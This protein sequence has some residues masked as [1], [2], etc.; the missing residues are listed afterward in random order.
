MLSKEKLI[1]NVEE[2]YIPMLKAVNIP[3]F[4]K[5]IA[6]FSGLHIK[7]VDDAVMKDYLLTWAKN[8]YRFYLKLGKKLKM[9]TQITYKDENIDTCTKMRGLQKEYF[10]F[11]LWLEEFRH[12]ENNKIHE[13]EVTWNIREIVN[14]LFPECRLEGCSLTHFFKSFL[15]APD[16][17]VNKIGRIWENQT[18]EGN[19][20]ISIDPIDM[21]L[22][23]ENP[24]EWVSCY[25]LALDN[26]GSHADGC[27]AAILDDSS[28]ITY[29]WSSEGKF[30]L[31][32]NYNFKN[33]RY[34]KMRKWI[35]VS[36]S[37]NAIHFNI[38]YP[39][40][41]SYSKEFEQTLRKVVEDVFNKDAIWKRNEDSG[42]N[43][44]RL[45]PYG[46]SE[47]FYDDIYITK[48]SEEEDWF[49]YNERIMCPCGCGDFLV[50][51]HDAE[52]DMGNCYNYNGEG[53]IAENFYVE[54]AEDEWCDYADD[55]CSAQDC[56]NCAI[57]NRYHPVC[58]LDHE[59]ECLYSEEAE[60]NGCFD[61]DDDCVVSCG[62]HCE[63]CRF[64][65][66]EMEASAIKQRDMNLNLAS[67]D[68]TP[69]TGEPNL[70]I[71]DAYQVTT[72]IEGV[73]YSGSWPE[74]P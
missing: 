53:F 30:S 4:Y 52:D 1:E 36:P 62:G 61:P 50:G 32:D 54:E 71:R 51:S 25:R 42:T 19:Y 24:Y 16:D 35:S 45:Y 34:Y 55:Y 63:E 23:S 14:R 70:V 49:V 33:I 68:I 73:M 22:A 59:H 3:D 13:R 66:Q 20:T 21:M 69:R 57:W 5:C 6:Q 28:L 41:H 46:Y 60:E 9:D 29:V 74:Y 64:H 31:Y 11:A 15:N 27:L 67:V 10:S 58:E 40:K 37:G 43:C 8:K 18:I 56:A 2:K 17:L 26:D 12:V 7:Y 38:T 72:T 47:F 48:D 39:G 65:K 44:K